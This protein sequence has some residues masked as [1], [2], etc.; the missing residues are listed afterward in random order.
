VQ[1]VFTTIATFVPFPV[2]VIVPGTSWQVMSGEGLV[3]PSV[4]FPVVP[5]VD[6]S[7]NPKT[8]PPPGVVL[9]VVGLPG[10]TVM[11]TGEFPLLNVAVTVCAAVK[12]TEQPAVPLQPAPVQPAKVEPSAAFAVSATTWPLAKLAEQVGWQEIPAGVLVTVPVPLPASVT[13]KVKFVADLVN[14][15]VTVVAAVTVTTHVPVPSHGAL[16][17]AN[18]EPV[19]GAAV[20]VTAVPLAKFALQVDGQVI[21]AGTLLTVP[22]PVPASATV[23]AK[24]VVVAVNVAVTVVA[25]VTVTTHV[26]VPS[27]GAL[28]PVKVDP[29][30]GAAVSVTCVPL[31]KLPAQVA[32]QLIPAGALVTV[33]VPVPAFV[34]VKVKL[35]VAVN[36]AATLVAAVI[37][38]T[39]VPVPEQGA[40]QPV[41]VD[42]VAGAA[43]KVTIV[44]LAKLAEQVAPQLIPAG[45]LVTVPV[46][47]PALTTVKVKFVTVAVK[48]AVTE[49]AAVTVTTQAP[50]PEQGAPQPVKVDPAAGAAVSVTCVPLAKLAEHVAPQLIPA[51]ALV[52]VPVPVPAFATVKVKFVAVGANVAVTDVAAVIVTTQVP[53]PE[54]GAPQP[55]NVEPVAAAAVKVTCVPLAKLAEHVAPQLI[56]AGALVTVPVP[57]PAFVTVKVKFVV[58]GANVAVTL[59]AAV[60]VTTQVPVPEHGVPQPVK[61]EPVAGAAVKVTCVPLAKLAEHVAPQLIPAGAL[62][63]VPVPVPAF[64]TVKAKFVVLGANVAVTLAAAVIVTTQVPVPEQGAPQPLNVE[65]VAAAAVSVTCVPLAKLDEHVAPQLI[66]AGAL[67]TV[68]VPVPAFVTD[69]VKFVVLGA[70][71]AV[72]LVAAVTVTTQVPVPEQGAP[73]PVKVDPVAGAAV[74]V[75]CV[76]LAKLAEQVAPQLI[77]AGALVTVPVPVPA[78]VT[79]KVKFVVLGANVAVT[80][81]AAVR[82]TT[83]VP[84][85][86]HGAPQPVNVEPVAAAAVKVTCVPLAKLAEHVAP[87]LI[88]AGALVTVPVPVPA[89]VTVKVKF[90]AAAAFWHSAVPNVGPAVPMRIVSI[91]HAEERKPTRFSSPV[92][93]NCPFDATE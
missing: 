8:A 51:G 87:Q 44:P 37:V 14:V 60:T 77:P 24:F 82:V 47:V 10:A 12:V 5:G 90:V 4:T 62:V 86:E 34:T 27:H 68:P 59:V 2:S 23:N 25:A 43:V 72:T 88:P 91:L 53:V 13:V 40:P 79:D 61:V 46:P 45:A 56:P 74:S 16:Q 20:K 85:P 49:V 17:P 15:A 84:V 3:H 26:P 70:N 38:T 66:P 89:F 36:V 31:A 29:V 55:L 54:Q 33:P 69:K 76:P 22:V 65:P 35:F 39:Q 6:V 41:N 7:S 32:P 50:V 28:Q 93:A 78:F 48:V 57:V 75:T 71:V 80:L 42:P 9:T 11:V 92:T 19:A 1:N 63:T 64:V 73:Q 30:A 81:V 58:L 67:V 52:T 18:V 83:Q 21:P